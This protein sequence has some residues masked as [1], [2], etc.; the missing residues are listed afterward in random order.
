MNLPWLSL[1][2]IILGGMLAM[3]GTVLLVM[4][5]F[6]RSAGWG[7]IVL[8]VP[9]GNIIFACLNWAEARRGFVA[10]LFGMAICLGGFFSIPDVQANLWNTVDPKP[11]TAT[12]PPDLDA[13][14]QSHRQQID[15]LQATFA[16][17]AITLTG[18]YKAL[19]AQRKALKPG[20]TAAIVKFNEAAAG[21]QTRNSAHK[22]MRQQIDTLQ[23][24]LEGLLD[25]R[26]RNAAAGAAPK[27]K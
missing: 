11:P 13:Q 12:P 24:E 20:D 8:L 1:A 6:R 9:L 18:E 15:T 2:A 25:T 26:A 5:A 3:A 16:Q 7:M 4:A 21:Y 22:Q 14:I 23:L 27:R 10:A 19:A 17:D